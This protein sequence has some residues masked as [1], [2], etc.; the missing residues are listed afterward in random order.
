MPVI[1]AT[2]ETKDHLNPGVQDSLGNIVS[3]NFIIIESL[4]IKSSYHYPEITVLLIQ[5]ILL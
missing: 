3:K 4:R 5:V 2:G 1:S